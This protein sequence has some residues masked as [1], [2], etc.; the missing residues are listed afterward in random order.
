MLSAIRASGVVVGADTSALGIQG[1]EKLRFVSTL[2]LEICFA[3]STGLVANI[4]SGS[5]SIMKM[6]QVLLLLTCP[7]VAG[8]FVLALILLQ[9]H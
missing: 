9:F 5:R 7:M 6:G 8:G 4:R 2:R 1:D 3:G